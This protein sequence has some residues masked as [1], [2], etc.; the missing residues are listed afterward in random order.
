MPGGKS[1]AASG[2]RRVTLDCVDPLPAPSPGTPGEGWGEGDFELSN[3]FD[4]P[5]SPS[6]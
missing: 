4:D 6:P 2:Q 3:D 1:W 5:K